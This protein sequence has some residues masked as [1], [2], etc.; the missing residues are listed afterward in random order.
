MLKIYDFLNFQG[1]PPKLVE[2][3]RKQNWANVGNLGHFA[4]NERKKQKM[5]KND[6]F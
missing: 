1:V 6:N 4:Q 5:L 2:I 3:S